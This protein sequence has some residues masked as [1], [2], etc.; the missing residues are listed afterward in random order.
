ML[1]IRFTCPLPNGLHARPASALEQRVSAF[2][3]RVQIGNL[4]NQRQADVRSVLAMIGTDILYQDPCE[5]VIEGE[6][7]SAAH[8][9]L[10]QFV[11][12]E[13]AAC[14]EPVA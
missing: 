2:Q 9:A 4:R 3:A 8:Q 7:E 10:T 6:D 13:F 12:Q 1:N 11:R 14:D 5:L